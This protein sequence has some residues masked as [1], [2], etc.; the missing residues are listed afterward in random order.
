MTFLSFLRRLLAISKPGL[1]GVV[2]SG[3]V[4]EKIGDKTRDKI[5]LNIKTKVLTLFLIRIR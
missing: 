1:P 5:T 2:K 4:G 3:F